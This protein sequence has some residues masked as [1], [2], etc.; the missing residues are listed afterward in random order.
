MK[1][2]GYP[3]FPYHYQTT[4]TEVC[5]VFF[6][7]WWTGKEIPHISYIENTNEKKGDFVVQKLQ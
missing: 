5:V 2:V 3:L 4:Q 7:L 6:F 1:L